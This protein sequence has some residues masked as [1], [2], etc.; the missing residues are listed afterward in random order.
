MKRGE[1]AV[2][3][4]DRGRDL[5]RNV[6]GHFMNSVGFFGFWVQW[7]CVASPERLLP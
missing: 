5:E 6:S 7:V 4:D 2:A 1:V 3:C